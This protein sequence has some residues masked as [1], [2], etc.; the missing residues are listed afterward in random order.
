MDV[1]FGGVLFKGDEVFR[2][3]Q[4]GIAD[5]GF[6]VLDRKDGFLLN[7]VMTLPF[8]GCRIST[9]QAESMKN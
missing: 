3:I 9:K 6:Y 7:S 5:A 1:H 8:M 4:K 2:G